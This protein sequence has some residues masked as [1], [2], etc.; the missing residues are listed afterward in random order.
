MILKEEN[1]IIQLRGVFL[2][3]LYPQ[4]TKLEI[5]SNIVLSATF[6]MSFDITFTGQSSSF[7]A[8][9]VLN[10]KYHHSVSKVIRGTFFRYLKIFF[11]LDVFRIFLSSSIQWKFH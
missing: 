4:D 11:H 5:I 9:Y 1:N 6:K 10:W 3:L 8:A 2:F 7:Y